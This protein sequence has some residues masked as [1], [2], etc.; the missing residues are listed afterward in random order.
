MNRAI[1]YNQFKQLNKDNYYIIDLR[2]SYNYKQYHIPNSYNLPYTQLYKNIMHIPKD[3]PLI[4]ICYNGKQ[5]KD[6]SLFF[7]HRHITSYYL[8]DGIN[9]FIPSDNYY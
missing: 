4:F 2:D 5:A 3:K 8:K 9:T 6:A 7:N 1:D